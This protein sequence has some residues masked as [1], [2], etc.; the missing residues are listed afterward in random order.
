M[1]LSDALIGLKAFK[2]VD[3]HMEQLWHNIEAAV[4]APRMDTSKSSLPQVRVDGDTLELV[5]EADRSVGALI[6]DLGLT[7]EFLATKLS[8]EFLGSLCSFMMND[9]ISKLLNQWLGPA[10]PSTLSGISTFERLIKDGRELASLLEDKG[11]SSIETLKHWVDNA[12]TIWLE[13]CRET[14]LD[15]IRNNL[16]SGIGQPKQVERV[17]KQMVSL[18]EGKELATTGAGANADTNDWGEAWGDAWD[19]DAQE[20]QPEADT[21]TKKNEEPKQDD[22]DDDG[23]D[24]WGW[25][26]EET[27]ETETQQKP[28]E[29]EPA[30]DD[31]DDDSAAAWGWG[32]EEV[33]EVK[34]APSAAAKTP[35]TAP[36]DETR[37]LVM[38]ETYHISSMPEPVL[39]LILTIL[40]DGAKLTRGENEY[41]HVASTAPGL[42]NLPTLILALFRAVSPHYYSLDGG[43]NMYDTFMPH[44]NG[45]H[46]DKHLGSSTTTPC[47]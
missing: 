39:E 41:A 33:P 45:F 44:G 11:Y 9:V 8:A 18:Q 12:P 10:V 17:E 32:D 27:T 37:E 46:A 4:I 25:D 29:T 40:E 14:A 5:G 34:P 22:D 1:A 19:D 3:E 47:I 31:D 35:K 23:A 24:A 15:T 26:D 43:G 21:T 36:Q 7:F 42:F 30:Q 20:P 13:K 28:A 2:E 38:K 6:K 16:A